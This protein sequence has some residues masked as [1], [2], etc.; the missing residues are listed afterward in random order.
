MKG[1]SKKH[2]IDIQHDEQHLFAKIDDQCS[3]II[4][5]NKKTIVDKKIV[6][7]KKKI[8]VKTSTDKMPKEVTETIAITD[9]EGTFSFKRNLR[10]RRSSTMLD[11]YIMTDSEEDFD[12]PEPVTVPKKCESSKLLPKTITTAGDSKSQKIKFNTEESA[13]KN[14]K[15]NKTDLKPKKDLNK[16]DSEVIKRSLS[17]T[18]SKSI[19]LKRHKELEIKNNKNTAADKKIEKSSKNKTE[20]LIFIN[21]EPKIDSEGL[22]NVGKK[23]PLLN[24]QQQLMRKENASNKKKSTLDL[25]NNNNYNNTKK[26]STSPSFTSSSMFSSITNQTREEL[27]ERMAANFEAKPTV[28]KLQDDGKT[29]KKIATA[30]STKVEN[31]FAV[32]EKNVESDKTGKKSSYS[33]VTVDRK[34]K[35]AVVAV[36]KK[37][38]NGVD[39]LVVSSDP[40]PL[41]ETQQVNSNVV[42]RKL[43]TSDTHH[44]KLELEVSKTEN[45]P[46]IL[47]NVTTVTVGTGKMENVMVV[48]KVDKTESLLLPYCNKVEK[49]ENIVFQSLAKDLFL[50]GHQKEIKITMP[51]YLSGNNFQLPN[52]FKQDD[53][54]SVLSEICSALPRF[55]EPFVSNR[56]QLFNNKL[57]VMSGDSSFVKYAHL[58]H[59]PTLV[60]V[61]LT[62]GVTDQKKEEKL[63]VLSPQLPQHIS[64]PPPPPPSF[65]SR[66]MKIVN[67]ARGGSNSTGVA[68]STCNDRKNLTTSWKQAFK[69]VKLP[70]NGLS[71][72][73]AVVALPGNNSNI[74]GAKR[75]Q[76]SNDNQTLPPKTPVDIVVDDT[77]NKTITAEGGEGNPIKLAMQSTLQVNGVTEKKSSEHNSYSCQK[78]CCESKSSEAFDGSKKTL[79]ANNNASY[80]A[81]TTILN[82]TKYDLKFEKRST[83]AAVPIVATTAT[84]VSVEKHHRKD[85][86]GDV[87]SSDDQ[88]PEKKIFNQ[89]RLSTNQSCSGNSSDAFSPDNE[90][91]VYAFQPDLPVAS[92]PFRRNKPQS[93]AKSRTVSP[94]T[95]IAVNIILFI[96]IR[97]MRHKTSIL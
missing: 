43:V 35:S 31:N 16:I 52:R 14:L 13:K 36:E 68:S 86:I 27:L 42:K 55:N 69:N 90:T 40:A 6:R 80:L 72:G 25:Y 73:G 7:E 20:P 39:S 34:I 81:K 64:L 21:I 37:I 70:K 29:T 56:Q 8:K 78:T 4:T 22:K 57:P 82:S 3:P 87:S 63:P 88:S 94:N 32:V 83:A 28:C 17:E 49:V 93:P 51:E 11:D 26:S 77:K 76:Q 50:Q 30:T 60:P 96:C 65:E 48:D 23:V 61:P 97:N 15:I 47:E 74:W 75:K 59:P 79:A 58:Q 9:N 92:T 91:S 67:L 24:K 41:M 71:S 84:P 38:Q 89:R 44:V 2:L 19:L 46:S 1:F 45:V 33:A 10:P 5:D 18:K 62:V 95:S 66:T 54:L 12:K 85:A 53:G